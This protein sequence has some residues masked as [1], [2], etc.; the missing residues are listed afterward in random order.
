MLF[1]T[2]RFSKEIDAMPKLMDSQNAMPPERMEEVKQKVMSAVIRQAAVSAS[3][4]NRAGVWDFMR[5]RGERVIRYV[6]SV[7]VGLSLLG[8]SAFAADGA[9]PGDVFYP[10]KRIKEKIQLSV[11]LSAEAKANLQARFAHERLKELGQLQPEAQVQTKVEV[12]NAINA[13]KKVKEIP[14]ET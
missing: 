4:R 5:E 6:V 3:A 2:K 9:K 12:N 13:L 10:V 7:L 8:G 14:C 11:S 1:N